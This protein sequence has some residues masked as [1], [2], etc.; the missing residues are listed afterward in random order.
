M[1]LYIF[2][3]TVA[4]A[5]ALS[6]LTPRVL[7]RQ[8]LAVGLASALVGSGVVNAEDAGVIDI[9]TTPTPMVGRLVGTSSTTDEEDARK[10][11]IL[12]RER[13]SGSATDGSYA[14]SLSKEQNKQKAMKKSRRRGDEISVRSLAVGVNSSFIL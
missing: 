7:S 9:I 14:T 4:L 11:R 12:A 1:L 5:P 6:W 13:E 8:T 10:V 2:I 3:L